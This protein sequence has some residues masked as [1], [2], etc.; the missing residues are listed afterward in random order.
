MKTTNPH[1]GNLRAERIGNS[2]TNFSCMPC[3][4]LV[5]ACITATKRTPLDTFFRND[6]PNDEPNQIPSGKYKPLIRSLL[7]VLLHI[8]FSAQYFVHLKRMFGA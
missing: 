8:P 2:G 1:E 5:Y 7:R 4:D 6:E 3:E